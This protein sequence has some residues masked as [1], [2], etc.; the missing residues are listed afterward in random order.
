MIRRTGPSR[1]REQHILPEKRLVLN[2]RLFFTAF[3][4]HFKASYY[5]VSLGTKPFFTAFLTYL[6]V[7]SRVNSHVI[8]KTATF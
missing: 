1:Y 6:E 2:R 4:T 3:L 7:S 5:A 8:G